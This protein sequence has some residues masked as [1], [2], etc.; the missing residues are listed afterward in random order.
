MRKSPLG[1]EDKIILNMKKLFVKIIL[2]LYYYPIYFIFQ[3]VA[4]VERKRENESQS[5]SNMSNAKIKKGLPSRVSLKTD[6]RA[7]RR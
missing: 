2:L 7:H 3:K 1:I 6:F 5:Y 4:P